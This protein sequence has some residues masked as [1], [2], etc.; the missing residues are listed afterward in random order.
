VTVPDV[1]GQTL[2][3]ATAT[4]QDQGL[5]ANPATTTA[6]EAG[7]NGT[8]VSQDPSGG[9]SVRRGSTVSITVCD[10]MVT[11][12]DVIGQT[13][14]QATTTLQDDGLTVDSTDSLNCGSGSDGL[15]VT[16]SPAAGTS[17]LTRSQVTVGVCTV[18]R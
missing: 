5:A 7:S 14:D 4:L 8:V 6:C 10:A 15:V 13:L 18:S 11:V 16:Q 1:I 17:V 3:G 9:Q 2:S 12:P